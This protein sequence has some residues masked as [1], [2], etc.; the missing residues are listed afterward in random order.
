MR[1]FEIIFLV[2]PDQGDQ[3]SAMVERYTKVVE[4]AK[5]AVHRVEDWGRRRLAYT[6]D[7]VHKAHY[8]LMNIEVDQATLQEIENL[9][10]FNDAIIRSLTLKMKSAVTE[11][12]VMLAS[13]ED[14]RQK[15]AERDAARA[16]EAAETEAAEAKATEEKAAKAAEAEKTAEAES[17]TEAKSEEEE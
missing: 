3:V 7:K 17:A 14:E 5:G 16:A 15:E 10:R 6:I 1:H 13:V 2:H 8:V 12:S 11:K 9:F 4:D